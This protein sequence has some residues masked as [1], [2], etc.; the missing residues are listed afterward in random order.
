[1]SSIKA[2]TKFSIVSGIDPQTATTLFYIIAG[3]AVILIFQKRLLLLEFARYLRFTLDHDAHY[4]TAAA[5][6]KG[7]CI[8]WTMPGR[9]TTFYLSDNSAMRSVF[10]NSPALDI[11]HLAE[12]LHFHGWEIPMGQPAIHAADKQVHKAMAKAKIGGLIEAFERY[13]AKEIARHVELVGTGR[14]MPLQ[15]MGYRLIYRCV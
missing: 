10:S 14:P 6:L 12:L 8:T 7:K 4:K 2:P 13:F 15:I 5:S 11:K 9:D 1:M 3:T